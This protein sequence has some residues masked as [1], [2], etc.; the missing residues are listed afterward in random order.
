MILQ[1]SKKSLQN[2]IMQ[3]IST[4]LVFCLCHS[5]IVFSQ[6][7]ARQY[8][9]DRDFVNIN[10]DDSARI[11]LGISVDSFVDNT[12]VEIEADPEFYQALESC[13]IYSALGV[14]NSKSKALV[15]GIPYFADLLMGNKSD[16]TQFSIQSGHEIKITLFVRGVCE[17]LKQGKYLIVIPSV[18]KS[19]ASVN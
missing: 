3:Y 18:E 15:V 10:P 6:D 12:E 9:P 16:V 17:N 13:D 8:L 4:A 1:Q 11:G 19:G 2:S 14:F 7:I 5:S